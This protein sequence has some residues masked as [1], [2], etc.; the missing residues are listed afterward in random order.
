[1]IH[2][3]EGITPCFIFQVR[4][5]GLRV[6]LDLEGGKSGNSSSSQIANTSTRLVVVH[7]YGHGGSGWTIMH[8]TANAAADLVDS[9]L[10][11]PLVSRL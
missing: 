7:N 1:M 2:F 9:A 5:K 3:R 10:R 4:A 11:K 8:G 6:E